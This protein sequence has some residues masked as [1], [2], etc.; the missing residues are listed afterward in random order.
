MPFDNVIFIFD[1]VSKHTLIIIAEM[2]VVFNV[3]GYL[4]RGEAQMAYI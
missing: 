2:A 3:A 4:I 1:F